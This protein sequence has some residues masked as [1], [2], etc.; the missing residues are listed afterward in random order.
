MA[1]LNANERS[2]FEM[3]GKSEEHARHGF[4]LLLKRR[5]L[6]EVL[7]PAAGDRTICPE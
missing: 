7:R 2:F 4:E 5:G 3:M 1:S 6:P